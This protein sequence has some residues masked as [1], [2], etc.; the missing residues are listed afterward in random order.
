M[1]RLDQRWVNSWFWLKGVTQKVDVTKHRNTSQFPTHAVGVKPGIYVCFKIHPLSVCYLWVTTFAW[2]FDK[3]SKSSK[4]TNTIHYCTVDTSLIAPK[5]TESCF[6]M[7]RW[8]LT[9]G[10]LYFMYKL[11]WEQGNHSSNVFTGCLQTLGQ[12]VLR[13][14]DFWRTSGTGNSGNGGVFPDD[15]HPWISSTKIWRISFDISLVNSLISQEKRFLVLCAS[16]RRAFE[17][18]QNKQYLSN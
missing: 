15:C 17:Y 18:F 12:N 9:V 3:K 4:V 8:D 16:L 13:N 6:Q 1:G 14:G 11:F 5:S 2:W 10:S 7:P